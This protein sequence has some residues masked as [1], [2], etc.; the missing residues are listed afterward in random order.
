M[1]RALQFTKCY[2]IVSFNYHNSPVRNVYKGLMGTISVNYIFEKERE[3]SSRH[4]LNH[5]EMS[6]PLFLSCLSLHICVLKVMI[7][8]GKCFL[9]I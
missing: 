7:G 5:P 1:Q 8:P 6:P 3:R 9:F 4:L 2:F